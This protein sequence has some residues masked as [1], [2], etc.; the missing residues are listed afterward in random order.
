MSKNVTFS[1]CRYDFEGDWVED[2]YFIHIDDKNLILKFNK[3]SDV[4]DLRD[5]LTN[6]IEEIRNDY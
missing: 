4:E 1:I 6:I 2:G 3:L 5:S